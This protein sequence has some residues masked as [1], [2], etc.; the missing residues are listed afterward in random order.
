MCVIIEKCAYVMDTDFSWDSVLDNLISTDFGEQVKISVIIP[1][2]NS[3]HLIRR[4]LESVINQTHQNFEIIIVDAD[5][6]DRTFQVIHGFA[7]HIAHVYFITQNSETLAY[8]KG[9]SLAKGEYVCLLSPGQAYISHYAFQYIAQLIVKNNY[10]DMVYGGSYTSYS[11]HQK[12]F[13]YFYPYTFH[14]LKS[15]ILPAT[16]YSYWI[17]TSSIRY[18]SGFD[19]RFTVLY[20]ALYD[21]LCRFKKDSTLVSLPMRRA[22]TEFDFTAIA[23]HRVLKNIWVRCSVITRHFGPIFGFTWIFHRANIH[24]VKWI[25]HRLKVILYGK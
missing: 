3:A 20:K 25:L 1:T 4:T 23:T 11:R 2:Y 8:N 6:T 12:P 5:S 18:L 22:F 16:T 21:F 10:P 13:V 9:L 15:G 19:P 14:M 7:K 24:L 17:K